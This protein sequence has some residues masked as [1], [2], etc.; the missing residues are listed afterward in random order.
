MTFGLLELVRPF[1]TRWGWKS[2]R[3]LSREGQFVRQF[4]CTGLIR[5]LRSERMLLPIRVQVSRL[6]I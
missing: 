6:G 3:Q 1:T 5:V 2:R 4:E